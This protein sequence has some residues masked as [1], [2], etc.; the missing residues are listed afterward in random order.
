MNGLITCTDMYRV[1]LHIESRNCFVDIHTEL[2]QFHAL[3]ALQTT[4]HALRFVNYT[5]GGAVNAKP[6]EFPGI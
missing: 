1:N 4:G 3:A 2:A 6:T 5:A